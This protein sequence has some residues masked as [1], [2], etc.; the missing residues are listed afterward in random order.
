MK[1]MSIAG[2]RPEIIKQSRI[3]AK[4]DENFDHVM[5]FTNQNYTPELSDI[6]FSDLQI[7]APDYNLKIKTESFGSEV[8]DLI[9]K[10]EKIMIKEKPDVLLLLGDVNS[11]LSAI[12]AA[13]L[14]IK[15]VHLEAGMR[16]YDKRMPEEKNRILIDHIAT[17]NLPYT[18]YSR[19][20]LIRENIHPSSIYVV[21]NP[22]I[23]VINYYLPKIK[24]STILT[25]LKL[26]PNQYVLVT[27]HRSENVDDPK[28]LKN[29]LLSLEQVSIEFK[30]RIIY[31][32]HPRTLSK[33]NKKDIP[34]CI[35]I[36][37]PLGFFEFSKLEQNAFC[38]VSDS[39]TLPE[40]ALY[41]KKPCVIIRESTERPEFI[42]AGCNILSGLDPKN[43]VDSVRTITSAVIDWE[44]NDSLG[45]GKTSSK[46]VNIIRGKLIRIPSKF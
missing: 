11:G 8:A 23:E 45:D 42:E 41:Y 14:G 12:P 5:V 36:I 19:Q 37:K 46:V 28:T 7:R 3:Y 44:W 17:V 6:F 40:D 34:K 30:K 39:G 20:N 4:L 24:K 16:A 32:M 31:P 26:K 25:K 18:E 21:G 27:A 13:H 10:I 35:E 9:S 33:I 15:I 2:T 1:V 38:Y 29:I 43:I 22:I